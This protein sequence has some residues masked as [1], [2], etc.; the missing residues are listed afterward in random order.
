MGRRA[1]PNSLKNA[2][3]IGIVA[4]VFT[5]VGMLITGLSN[6]TASTMAELPQASAAPAEIKG[7]SSFAPVV[8]RVKPAVVFITN[9]HEVTDPH[10]DF[11]DFDPRL[12][13][14][15]GIPE[16]PAPEKRKVSQSGSGFIINPEGYIL[17]NNHVIE[18]AKTLKVVLSDETEYEA[19]VVGSDP[20]TDLAVIKLKD[21][22]GDLPYAEL[23]N[24]DD[25]VPGDWAIAIGN[26]F[27]LERTV[28]VGVISATGRSGLHIAGGKAVFQNFLQTDASINFGNSG[29]PLVD[30]NGRVIGINTAI[31]S[32]AQ[33]IGFAIPINMARTIYEQLRTEG[34]VVRGYLGMIPTPLTPDK[35]EALGLDKETTGIFVD[36]VEPGTPADEGGL[37]GGDVITRWNGEEVHSVPDFRFKVAAVKPGEKAEAEIIRDGKRRTLE[38]VMGDRSEYLASGGTGKKNSDTSHSALGIQV[39]NL[40]DADLRDLEG[41]VTS[42]VVVVSVDDDSPAVDD[43]HPGDII[44]EIDRH[45]VKDVDEFRNMVD[46]IRE[47]ERAVL[48]RI[49]RNGRFTFETIKP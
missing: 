1:T 30:I 8:K 39:R 41:K 4:L 27:G 44:V 6:H 35:K 15:F 32:A 12:R 16:T 47:R 20:E 19:E 22:A 11:F 24:S 34:K 23:G 31:N 49:F 46:K 29:G 2:I 48:F 45:S 13:E 9:T 40:A 43:L 26:P 36:N 3:L 37:Q 7:V 10:A 33:G 21:P 28:T 38:F 14:F 5:Y 25:V 17:T 18:D 42:G